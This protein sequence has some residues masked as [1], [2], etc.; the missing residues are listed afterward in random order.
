[1][2]KDETPALCTQT[3]AKDAMKY[4]LAAEKEVYTLE[5]HE[6]EL[7]RLAGQKVTVKGILKGDTLHRNRYQLL[8]HFAGSNIGAPLS[9]TKNTTNF[10]GLVWLA[11]RPTT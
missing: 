1:M 9:L 8:I 4:A 2:A 10:A 6:A 7:A 3:C 5:G 11:F